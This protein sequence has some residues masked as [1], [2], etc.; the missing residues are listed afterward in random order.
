MRKPA[1]LPGLLC[2]LHINTR[3]PP[4][5][6]AHQISIFPAREVGDDDERKQERYPVPAHL[7][8]GLDV[9]TDEI[10]RGHEAK[11]LS[12]WVHPDVG[13]M[14]RV[15]DGDVSAHPLREALAREISEHGCRMDEDVSALIRVRRESWDAYLS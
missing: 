8:S 7:L 4:Y 12:E 1:A 9:Q 6:A 15:P 11:V 2:W 14:L 10:T 5:V 13:L 3:S